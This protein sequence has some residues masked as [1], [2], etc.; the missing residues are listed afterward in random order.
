MD[1]SR[2]IA[3]YTQDV[4]LRKILGKIARI[5]DSEDARCV[6]KAFLSS[7]LTSLVKNKTPRLMDAAN[8]FVNV[9]DP[10]KIYRGLQLY[11]WL[12]EDVPPGHDRETLILL[13]MMQY[14]EGEKKTESSREMIDYLAVR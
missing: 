3:S 12:M 10:V 8:A 4:K 6:L 11:I 5:D 1:I 9:Q 14:I 13:A 7:E 2:Q